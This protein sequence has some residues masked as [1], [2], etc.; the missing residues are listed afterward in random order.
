M[1]ENFL[2]DQEVPCND[3]IDA[4]FYALR[5]GEIIITMLESG[6]VFYSNPLNIVEGAFQKQI[7]NRLLDYNQDRQHRSGW[8][9]D[10][11]TCSISTT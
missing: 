10:S 4:R 11:I 7:L 5:G 6:Q 3:S 1:N 2:L 8:R 9:S